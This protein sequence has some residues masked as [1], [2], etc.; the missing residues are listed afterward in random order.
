MTEPCL[1]DE[2]AL[3][4]RRFEALCRVSHAAVGWT[5]LSSRTAD[6]VLEAMLDALRLEAGTLRYCS[7]GTTESVLLAEKG[8]PWVKE[9]VGTSIQANGPVGHVL[10]TGQLVA[11]SDI[12]AYSEVF[13]Q[14]IEYGFK[15]FIGLPLKVGGRLAGVL[16]GLSMQPRAFSD[17]DVEVFTAIGNVV[18]LAMANASLFKSTVVARKQW[19]QAFDAMSE[20][21]AFVDLD[22][23]V[24]RVNVALA[25]LL[26]TTPEALVGSPCYKVLHRSNG[27]AL[28]CP[29]SS[30]PDS[31]SCAGLM[32]GEVRLDDRWLEVR[33]D[34]VKGPTG[35]LTGAI[36][37]L[38][39][40]TDRKIA[41][42]NE[43]RYKRLNAVRQ[44]SEAVAGTLDL[45]LVAALALQSI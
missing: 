8:L 9:R 1:S 22:H 15:S 13:E 5:D 4:N 35:E 11:L 40:I 17:V 44:V 34:P 14:A 27:P 41:E 29:L 36:H 10:Q 20:G 30:G 2:T 45:K 25:R 21:V 12:S 42:E 37:V 26:N 23:R 7:E 19:E 18:G 39:D 43:A 16:T 33:V 6:V 38:R 31:G 3:G 32:D 24:T 28:G